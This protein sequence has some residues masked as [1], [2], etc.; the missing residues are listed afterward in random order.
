MLYGFKYDGRHSSEFNLTVTSVKRRLHAPI[1]PRLVSVPQKPGAYNYGKPEIGHLVIEVSVIFIANDNASYHDLRRDIIAWLYRDKEVELVFDDEP[2]KYYMAQYS[3]ESDID[4]LGTAGS[5][6]LYFI[7]SDPYA[8]GE[9]KTQR[10]ANPHVVFQREGIRYRE[11][12]SEVT[13]NYPIYKPGK[14]DQSI[15]IE[16]GTENLL[17]SAS[18]PAQEEVSVAVGEDYYLSRISGIATIEHKW[19]ETLGQSLDKEGI[20]VSESSDWTAGTHYRT[21]GLPIGTLQLEKGTDVNRIW[22]T[23]ADWLGGTLTGRLGVSG[24]S[25]R[26]NTETWNSIADDMDNFQAQGWQTVGDPIIS[27]QADHVL[28]NGVNPV[29]TQTRLYKNHGTAFTQATLDFKASINGDFMKAWITN[30]TNAWRVY[31]PNTGGEVRWFRIRIID[32]MTAE[33]YVNGV[34]TPATIEYTTSTSSNVQFYIQNPGESSVMRI[35]RVYFSTTDKGAPP[36]DGF[37]TGMWESEAVDLSAVKIVNT[38]SI[39][40]TASYS[41]ENIDDTD[42]FVEV[43]LIVDGE[44]QGWISVNPDLTVPGLDKGTN[45]ENAAIKFRVT[46]RT[47]DPGAACSMH[48]LSLSVTSGYYPNGY[49]E[50][51]QI[52]ISPAVKAAETSITWEADSSAG[53]SVKVYARLSLDRG[54]M[55][56][57]WVEVANSG[58]PIPGITQ[59]TDLTDARLQYRVELATADTSV[60]PTVDLLTISLVSGYK[61][62]QTFSLTPVNVTNIG[63]AAGSFLTWIESKPDGTDVTVE[64][65]VDGTNWTPVTNGG[66]PVSDGTDLSG[67]SLHIRYTLSTTDTRYTP[68]M[69]AL[70]WKVAQTEPHRIKPATGTIVLTPNGVDRWQLEHKPYPTGW[71]PYGS[72]RN[73]ET[74]YIPIELNDEQGTI[75]LWIYEDGRAYDRYV[76]D[77]G[78]LSLRKASDGNYYV[79]VNGTDATPAISPPSTGWRHWA[80]RW[81]GTTVDVF[82]DGDVVASFTFDDPIDFENDRLYVGCSENGMQWNERIDDIRISSVA[83]S[84]TEIAAIYNS[85]EPA[86]VDDQ[87]EYKIP[88][89]NT[90]APTVDDS[91][92]IGGTA[93]TQGIFIAT[94]TN[95]ASYFKISNG[96]EYIQVDTNFK[97]GDVLEIDCVREVV[98]KN[99]SREAA[100]PFLYIESDFFDLI[101]GGTVFVEPEGAAQ[102]DATFTERWR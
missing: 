99:G 45:V 1:K 11:D 61:P 78:A 37:Y 71:H 28:I 63:K 39:N 30:G 46:L 86:P 40:A 25:L 58:D 81:N 101:P 50:S 35:Y 74:A 49:F 54:D 66:A 59:T 73:P 14:F 65:S 70:E 102:V 6:T 3:E 57:D 68:I 84:D 53:T 76:F 7:S 16:E 56:S 20:D 85:G 47:M 69:Q 97:P 82:I 80:V 12:G 79:K 38:N 51:D 75:E 2:D 88:F 48:D 18:A 41:G 77:A 95:N 64:A 91:I 17:V 32:T 22:T 33:L 36:T 55:W 93:P 100:M 31:L 21:K 52:D 44:E 19:A 62:L 42:L 9:T 89:D 23:D 34:L 92:E 10:I 90:L 67:K 94:F 72:T 13:E 27:Q 83:R 4:R 26:L 29:T 15:A 5:T 24:G 98:R 60:T 96:I 8:F 87:T 43:N